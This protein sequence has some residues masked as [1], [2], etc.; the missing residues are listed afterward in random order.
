LIW[1]L[2][3]KGVIDGDI[4]CTATTGNVDDTVVNKGKIIGEVHL[5]DGADVF[6]GKAGAAV[7]VFGELGNDRL[8]GSKKTDHL[9]GGADNDFITGHRGKDFQTGGLG[10]D[11]FDFNSI[12]DSVKGGKRDKILDFSRSESDKI[13]LKGIDAKQGGGNQKFKW[14]GKHDFHGN[15]G[16]L[17]Y[18]DKGSKVIVQRDVNGD[19]HSDFEIWVGVDALNKGDFLL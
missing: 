1:H 7:F 3:N 12:K 9:D 19:G 6:N 15:A 18:Q 2:T 14:I 16:E 8:V 5:G 4:V 10:A 13:D 17:R 11:R